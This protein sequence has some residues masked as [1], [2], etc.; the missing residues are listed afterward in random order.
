MIDYLIPLKFYD[1]RAA[2]V[3][4]NSETLCGYSG[5]DRGLTYP[6]FSHRPMIR[7]L[8]RRPD[9]RRASHRLLSRLVAALNGRILCI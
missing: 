4:L 2:H 1:V 7:D 9:K 6:P 3:H 5:H 8:L